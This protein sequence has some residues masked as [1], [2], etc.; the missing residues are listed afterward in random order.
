VPP[1]RRAFLQAT[2]GIAVGTRGDR[3]GLAPGGAGVRIGCL[4]RDPDAPGVR[5]LRLG[6]EEAAHAARRRDRVLDVREVASDAAAERLARDGATVALVGPGDGDDHGVVAAAARH[7]RA[8]LGIADAPTGAANAFAM[9]PPAGGYLDAVVRWVARERPWG[10]WVV[11]V[12]DADDAAWR[13]R[14]RAAAESERTASVAEAVVP[15][16]GVRGADVL[17]IGARAAASPAIADAI[18]AV[19]DAAVVLPS[20][21]VTPSALR[22]RSVRAMLWHESLTD[23]GAAELNA[24]FTR[25]FGCAMTGRDWSGWMA[26]KILWEAV[27]RHGTGAPTALLARGDRFDGHK[28]RTLAFDAGRRLV[29]PVYVVAGDRVVRVAG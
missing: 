21:D 13:S 19:P 22:R 29:Q 10:R 4:V 28:G 17:L 26:F 3:G 8:F 27:A 12:T 7:G 5:G 2:I 9:A 6:A 16:D 14:A 15:R 24:R 1:T 20:G 11:V 25:R 23:D 18:A